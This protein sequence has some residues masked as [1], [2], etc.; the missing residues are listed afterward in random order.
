VLVD[1]GRHEA[2]QRVLPSNRHP[3][4][5]R[6]LAHLV[7]RGKRR[8]GVRGQAGREGAAGRRG[9]SQAGSASTRGG[10]GDMSRPYPAHWRWMEPS[11]APQHCSPPPPPKQAGAQRTG[12][13]SRQAPHLA[14]EALWAA[15][16][17]RRVLRVAHLHAG[18]GQRR[19]VALRGGQG[20][21]EG[22]GRVCMCDVMGLGRG[23]PLKIRLVAS[24]SLKAGCSTHVGGPRPGPRRLAGAAQVLRMA[25]SEQGPAS[26]HTAPGCR[27]TRPASR[28]CSTLRYD[29]VRRH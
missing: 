20:G 24:E 19:A 6:H 29:G 23:V 25:G 17:L 4:R 5:R 3:H 18:Q 7:G 13:H 21:G 1:D 22:G 27:G 15:Q 2:G 14:Q 16:R 8:G 10:G 26:P 12:R 9:V 28:C 11:I